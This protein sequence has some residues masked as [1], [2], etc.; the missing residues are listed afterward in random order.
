MKTRF[1]QIAVIILFL[2]ATAVAE[3]IRV[4][5]MEDV[6]QIRLTSNKPFFVQTVSGQLAVRASYSAADVSVRKG[7]TVN[8]RDTLTKTVIFTPQRGERISV[9]GAP[10]S[11]DIWVIAKG[12]T[13]LVVNEVDLEYYLHGVVPAEM[14]GSWPMEALKA[15]AVISRTYALYQKRKHQDRD[16]DLSATVLG[17]VYK[18]ESVHHPA[19]SSAVFET[20]RLILAHD[21]EP[22]LTFFHSTSAGHTEDAMERWGI[23]LPYLKGVSCPLDQESPY[24]RWHKEI[25]LSDLED[26]VRKIGGRTVAALTPFQYGKAGRILTVRI[27]HERGE[28]VLEAEA[29]RKLLG[30]KN[31]PSTNFKIDSFGKILKISGSGFGHG[32]GLCQWGAKV[33]AERGL[34]FDEIV[35]YYYPGTDL[36]FR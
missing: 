8:Q 30:Y 3:P 26:A 13:L 36:R 4:A 19:A 23:D 9:N 17:Q 20:E 16:Y 12:K 35:L 10:Y 22:A 5:L 27:L 34:K 18:G 32:V 25:R 7:I 24:Y 2:P 15:Q 28:T 11:G 29:L 1:V 6:R 31:L 21:G 33:M 14:P